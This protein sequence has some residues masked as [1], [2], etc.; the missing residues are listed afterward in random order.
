MIARV[1]RATATEEGA[2]GYAEHFTTSVLPELNGLDGFV[3]AFL[4]CRSLGDRTEIQVITH[5]DSYDEIRAFAGDDLGVAVVEPAAR[6]V[7][8]TYGTTVE[9]Y[10]IVA[11]G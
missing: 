2:R 11:T 7:L 8:T 3:T 1:W 5:W 10:E 9:H 6:R 4:L